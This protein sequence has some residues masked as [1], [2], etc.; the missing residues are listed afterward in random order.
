M[1]CHLFSRP[2]QVG[3]WGGGWGAR[4]SSPRTVSSS[5]SAA[6][7]GCVSAQRPTGVAGLL[8]GLRL[9]LGAASMSLPRTAAFLSSP[10]QETVCQGPYSLPSGALCGLLEDSAWFQVGGSTFKSLGPRNSSLNPP[11]LQMGKQGPC[12]EQSPPPG[13]EQAAGEGTAAPAGSAPSRPPPSTSPS[14]LRAMRRW[15][16]TWRSSSVPPSSRPSPASAGPA[17]PR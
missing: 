10:H 13:A 4:N 5:D 3:R 16:T 14:S 17:I 1:D 9:S 15:C 11:I 2:G 12:G 8:P 6:Q 7:R